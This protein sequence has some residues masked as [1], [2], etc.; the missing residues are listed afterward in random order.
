LTK[1]ARRRSNPDLL[2]GS[3]F[4]EVSVDG[5][6]R[7]TQK[8]LFKAGSEVRLLPSKTGFSM[9]ITKQMRRG[10]EHDCFKAI[11]ALKERDGNRDSYEIGE[12]VQ[13]H[14]GKFAYMVADDIVYE[15][16]MAHVRQFGKAVTKFAQGLA[17]GEK[18]YVHEE[19]IKTEID[20]RVVAFGRTPEKTAS[21][22]KF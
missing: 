16:L 13:E 17:S 20:E 4:Q 10:V 21:G 12:C 5:E 18:Y 14:I 15:E 8:H 3:L 7:I 9:T 2:P 6:A 11:R 1:L 22:P 19:H